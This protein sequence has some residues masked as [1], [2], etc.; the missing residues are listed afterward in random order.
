[1]RDFSSSC[2]ASPF[3]TVES[4]P[5]AIQ[6][7]ERERRHLEVL[8]CDHPLHPR[9][10]HSPAKVPTEAISRHRPIPFVCEDRTALL[11]LL[12]ANDRQIRGVVPVST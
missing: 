4:V 11:L 12:F 6:G 10:E 1:M 9:S 3:E 5:E 7:D 2:P 8:E